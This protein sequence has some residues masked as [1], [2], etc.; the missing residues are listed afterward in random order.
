M[1]ASFWLWLISDIRN[2]I[3]VGLGIA[4]LVLGV[5]CGFLRWDV[6]AK[7]STISELKVSNAQLTLNNTN[8]T[9]QNEQLKSANDAL[10]NY[11]AN[12]LKI[13][14]D[15]QKVKDS[16]GKIGSKEDEIKANNDLVDLWSAAAP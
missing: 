13:K 14:G 9:A 3:I 7:D 2:W 5:Y 15:L 11:A 10:K 1:I 4:V 6:A 16:I 8:L 12:L